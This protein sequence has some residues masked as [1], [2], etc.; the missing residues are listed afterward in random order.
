M[1]IVEETIR[2]ER[3][4]P[5]RAACILVGDP[6]VLKESQELYI[7]YTGFASVE[8]CE[9]S[10]DRVHING[11]LRVYPS[12]M[13]DLLRGI[14]VGCDS[15]LVNDFM[16]INGS[17]NNELL[18]KFIVFD[19]ELVIGADSTASSESDLVYP[20][21]IYYRESDLLKLCDHFGITPSETDSY[22]VTDSA[23]HNASPK[24]EMDL[25]RMVGGLTRLLAQQKGIDFTREWHCLSDAF[26]EELFE[27]L[28]E[29]GI[30]VDGKNKF[31]YERLILEGVRSVN[32][33]H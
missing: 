20:S 31:L 9:R 3:F 13:K 17:Y 22:L 5:W 23:L 28:E 11:F 21:C 33:D 14:P 2:N 1:G 12:D 10:Y 24:R 30:R 16:T 32:G 7:R 8:M 19:D 25:L 29:L 26:I 6:Q 4:I 15:A 27:L 18:E